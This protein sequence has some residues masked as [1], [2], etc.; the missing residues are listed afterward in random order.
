VSFHLQADLVSSA[1]DAPVFAASPPGQ[2]GLLYVLE[3][4]TGQVRVLDLASG[5][6]A[7]QPFFALPPGEFIGQGERGLLGMA[8]HPDYAVNG[9]LYLDFINENGDTEIWEVTRSALDPLRADAASAHP[10]LTI[11]RTARNHMGGWLGFGPDGYLYITSGDSGVARDPENAAQNLDD[12]R[13]KLLRIDVN[14]DDFPLDALRNYGIPAGN[15]FADEIF[16][17]GLRNPW[18]ASFDRATGDLYIADVGQNAREEIDYLPAGAGAGSNFGWRVIE[19]S[20]PTG[21]PQL[22]NPD[23]DD[24]GLQGPILEYQHGLGD[25]EGFSITGGYV[26]QGL[27]FFADF[28]SEHLWTVRV[29]D[30]QA[31]ELTQHDDTRVVNGGDLDRIA[32][33]AQDGKGDLFAIGLDGDIHRIS[34]VAEPMVVARQDG[35]DDG[36]L[37]LG[38]AGDA[39]ALL[40]LAFGWLI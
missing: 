2:D 39:A 21:Y 37:G 38:Q 6:V 22:S 16:A 4:N 30:G 14:L 40:A 3:K 36:V 5:E 26:Y 15:P 28:V 9:R 20:R 12:L 8:F 29:V 10:I 32:S 35:D 31:T 7:A 17:Y 27:Y 18:R 34:I 25:F 33:F 23:A 24:P 13:G 19:G 1:F 11:D